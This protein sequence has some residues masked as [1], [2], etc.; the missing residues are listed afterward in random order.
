MELFNFAQLHRAYT[1]IHP[2]T[3]RQAAPLL[4]IKESWIRNHQRKKPP[5][6]KFA[7][8]FW[9]VAFTCLETVNRLCPL[10][11][12]AGVHPPR[13]ATLRDRAH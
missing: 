13:H 2:S 8:A 4:N 6:P 11:L 1:N 7:V 3:T 5:E 12:Q 10:A 9:G